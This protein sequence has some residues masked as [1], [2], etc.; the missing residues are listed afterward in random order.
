MRVA[1]EVKHLGDEPFLERDF[2]RA[3]ALD[4]SYEIEALVYRQDIPDG[5]KLRAKTDVRV[6]A[7]DA[8][9][10]NVGVHDLDLAIRSFQIHRHNVEGG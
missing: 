4:V 7:L 1:L 6:L 5:V 3:Q 10:V 2:V 8:Q 9:L